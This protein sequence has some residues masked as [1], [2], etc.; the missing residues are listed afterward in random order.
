MLKKEKVRY[1]ERIAS[2]NEYY[3]EDK[4]MTIESE[5]RKIYGNCLKCPK[6]LC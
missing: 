6:I 2:N 5:C 3:P 4:A 1:T